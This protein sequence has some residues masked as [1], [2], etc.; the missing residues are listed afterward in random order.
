MQ[1]STDRLLNTYQ[2][3]LAELEHENLVLKTL[4]AQMQEEREDDHV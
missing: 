3:R 2:Q 1:I 4:V